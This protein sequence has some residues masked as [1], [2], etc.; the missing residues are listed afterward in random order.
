LDISHFQ[1]NSLNFEVRYDPAFL[2]WDKAGSL[3]EAI[4]KEHPNLKPNEA[5]PGKISF[6]IDKKFQVA[7]ELEKLNVSAFQPNISIDDFVAL[8]HRVIALAVNTL[9]VTLFLRI[10]LRPIYRHEYRNRDEAAAALIGTGI[11]EVPEGRHF[12]IEGRPVLPHYAIRWE[13]DKLAIQVNF[14]VQ[15]RKV[16]LQLPLGETAVPNIE[17]DIIE[18]IYDFDYFTVGSVEV[19]QFRALDWIPNAMRVIRRDSSVFLKA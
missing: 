2:L 8:C 18:L 5:S 11:M 6:E 7:F 14:R 19:G 13:G 17:K 9:Q 12:G 10:G 15:E 16:T 4:R 3:A 1:L